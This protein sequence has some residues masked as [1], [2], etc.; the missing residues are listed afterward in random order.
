MSGCLYELV[1]G[2]TEDAAD[3]EEDEGDED[4]DGGVAPEVVAELVVGRQLQEAATEERPG[5]ETLFSRTNPRLREESYENHCELILKYLPW[6]CK[7]TRTSPVIKPVLKGL[8]RKKSKNF[9]SEYCVANYRDRTEH[10]DNF[11]VG[12]QA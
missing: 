8:K 2:H 5:E 11:P 6:H 3:G 1:D 12:S 10:V 4:D 9:C 7:C